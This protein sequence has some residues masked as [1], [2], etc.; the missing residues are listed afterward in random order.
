MHGH[1]TR[2][3]PSCSERAGIHTSDIGG[4]SLPSATQILGELKADLVP[5]Y[6]L[7]SRGYQPK[8]RA[9]ESETIDSHGR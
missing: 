8:N 2:L 1:T 3:A 4:G 5:G 9:V 6:V 7:I